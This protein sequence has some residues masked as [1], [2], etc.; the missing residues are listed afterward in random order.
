[1]LFNFPITNYSHLITAFHY[2]SNSPT[3]SSLLSPQ[4]GKFS[5]FKKLVESKIISKSDRSLATVTADNSDKVCMVGLV[6]YKQQITQII[7]GQNID[8]KL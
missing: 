5:S 4:I 3:K 7:K 6:K 8:E 1:M 2:R